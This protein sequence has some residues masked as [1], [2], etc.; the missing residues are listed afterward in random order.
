[1][2]LIMGATGNIG[3]ALIANL[4]A[5]GVAVRAFVRDSAK[6]G[7]LRDSGVE[8]AVGDVADAA[9]L[10]AGMT[11]IDR[12]FLLTPSTPD[13]VAQQSAVVAAAGR[14]GIQQ[15]VKLSGADAGPENPSIFARWHGE[16]EARI[17]QSG[18]AYTFLQPVFFMQ[19]F[20]TFAPF[21]AAQ[22]RFAMPVPPELRFNM[23]DSRDI[24]AVAAVTLTEEG[25]A[26]KTYVLTSPA[27]LSASETAAT[28][29]ATLGKPVAYM[30]IPA[31]TMKQ[32]MV[33]A[34]QPTWLADGVIEL[35]EHM[36]SMVSDAVGRVTGH[37]AT[38]F[39]EFVQ[40]HAGAFR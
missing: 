11:G 7:G 6:A 12:L 34:G 18:I 14:A 39:A 21:I 31:Q 3:G 17:R 8:I 16:V 40:H 20:L 10:D 15:I 33:S 29:A 22:G 35:Y 28:L 37:P 36:D 26:G 30:Q 38:T 19:N 9:S 27:L 32:Q 13:Q 2:I 23:V 25:H 4:I 5:E 1:M 24:A